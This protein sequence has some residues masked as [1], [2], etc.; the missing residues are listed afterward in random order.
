MLAGISRFGGEV[1]QHSKIEKVILISSSFD[2]FARARVLHILMLGSS[3]CVI[4]HKNVFE[5][6]P[7]VACQTILLGMF[8]VLVATE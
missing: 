7:A 8:L 3:L 5:L 6:R 1:A 2:I 4:L